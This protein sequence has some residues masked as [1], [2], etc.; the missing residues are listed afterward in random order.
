LPFNDP[1]RSFKQCASENRHSYI[2]KRIANI[3]V[4]NIPVAR[5]TCEGEL[6]QKD[7][8][9]TDVNSRSAAWKPIGLIS[10]ALFFASEGGKE[11]VSPSVTCPWATFSA[12]LPQEH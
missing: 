2:D 12:R 10:N 6:A 4:T 9:K 1:L 11:L 5:T 7:G 3:E 8:K